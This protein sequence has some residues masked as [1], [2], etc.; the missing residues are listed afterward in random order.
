MHSHHVLEPHFL[1]PSLAGT[2][3]Q[4][5]ITFAVG[6]YLEVMTFTV[7]HILWRHKTNAQTAVLACLPVLFL[8]LAGCLT[9]VSLLLKLLHVLLL[10]FGYGDAC[11]SAK[12]HQHNSGDGDDDAD[13]GGDDGDEVANQSG[14][15]P[16]I[17]STLFTAS[18]A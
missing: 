5:I 8:P 7:S 2:C 3:Q 9:C 10:W 4:K 15:V 6:S 16:A 18:V 14:K 1:E 17:K 11:G 13:E 12:E